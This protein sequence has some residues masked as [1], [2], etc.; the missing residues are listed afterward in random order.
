[1]AVVIATSITDYYWFFYNYYGYYNIPVICSLFVLQFVP[2]IILSFFFIMNVTGCNKKFT[3]ILANFPGLWLLP[4][5]TFFTI[6]HFKENK[7]GFSKK[8]SIINMIVTI[9]MYGITLSIFHFLLQSEGVTRRWLVLTHI[10]W[11]GQIFTPVLLITLFLNVIFL[12]LDTN[13]CCNHSRSCVPKMCCGPSCYDFTYHYIE[14]TDE[15]EIWMY[16]ED[17]EK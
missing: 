17:N 1:M 8:C 11:F 7:L 2:N 14:T 4:V 10:F 3:K 9:A 16:D 15:I 13:C 5:A 6:G 12:L